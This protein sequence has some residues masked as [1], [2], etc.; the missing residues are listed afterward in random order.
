M[1]N[2]SKNVLNIY[3]QILFL[4]IGSTQ[5]NYNTIKWKYKH[6]ENDCNCVYEIRKVSNKYTVEYPT[7]I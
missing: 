2:K 3:Y 5:I 4:S 6:S 7:F 1:K